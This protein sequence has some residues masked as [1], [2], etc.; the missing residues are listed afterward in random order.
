MTLVGNVHLNRPES[1]AVFVNGKQSLFF[2]HC[3]T[4]DLKQ[5][6]HVPARNKTVILFAHDSI[7][8]SCAWVRNK[9][10][11]LKLLCTIMTFRSGVDVLDELVGEQTGTRSTRH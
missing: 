11:N 10:P 9:T 5:L 7:M 8:T 1:A 3:C 2:Y 6:S 4:S